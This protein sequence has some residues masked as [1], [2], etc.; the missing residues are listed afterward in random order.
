M[1]QNPHCPAGLLRFFSITIIFVL[2]SCGFFQATYAQ[3]NGVG[4]YA[5][6][7][8]AFSSPADNAG[9]IVAASF[10][11]GVFV[12]LNAGTT[13]T[14][15]K[16]G[17]TNTY[18]RTIVA[19]SSSI[20][21]CGTNDNIA[22]STDGGHTWVPVQTTA[23][24]VRSLAF[25]PA[26]GHWFAATYGDDFYRSI[27][28]GLTWTKSTVYDPVSNEA[29][30]HLRIVA[31]FGADSIYVGGSIADVTTGGALFGSYDG[32]LTWKQMQRAIGIRSSVMSISVSPASPATTFIMGTALKGV[33]Q[34]TNGGVNFGNIDGTTTP[35]PLPSVR[36]NTTGLT[37]GYRLSGTDSTCGVYR[38]QAAAD[39]TNGW[40]A[41]AGIPGIPDIPEGAFEF[42]GGADVMMGFDNVGAYR[43]VDSAKTFSPAI[44]GMMGTSIRDIVFTPSG[45]IIICAGFGDRIFHSDNNG[46]AWVADSVGSYSSIFRLSRSTTGV[47]Y[48]AQYGTGVIKSA[49]QGLTWTLTDTLNVNHFVRA[50]DADPFNANVVYA[51]TGNGVYKST[52]AGTSWTNTNGAT[53]PF[54]TSIHSLAI[55]PLTSGLVLAGTDSS[56][57]FRSTNGGT[58]WA[59]LTSS[60]GFLPSDMYMR[61]IDFDPTRANYVYVGSDSGRIY[62]STNAGASW[63]LFFSLPTVNSVRHVLVDPLNVNFMFTATFG[64]GLFVSEDGG[65]TWTAYNTGMR[66]LDLWT[67][68]MRPGTSPPE[69]WI[70]SDTSGVFRRTYNGLGACTT[71][72]DANS[73]GNIDISDAVFLIQYIFSGGARPGD[74][75]YPY[76]QGDANGDLN[77]DISDAV[78]L[79]Q[80]IFAGGAV[81][82]CG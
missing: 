55:S 62:R 59:H 2:V 36:V 5:K 66:S 4:P 45:R 15:Y 22:R 69:L 42:A 44:S 9:M 21:L 51:G 32:G 47:L 63:S 35:K 82:H 29:M 27:N 37:S 71:C 12:S 78:F 16:T 60:A 46:V 56:F 39:S 1:H 57:L 38:R 14:N 61:T 52:D 53:I 75:N 31:R 17:L 28:D 18:V 24:S 70:G 77:V 19:R 67:V 68:A 23:F 20:M 3:W 40:S 8:R 30:H 49:D 25:D 33:Y 26:T 11:W 13:W 54:S 64:G 74:C 73:D 72:G 6:N 41:A 79:I 81:P 7:I 58:T 80:Y 48:G 10:G 65:A 43:S 50:V 76:G 34:S